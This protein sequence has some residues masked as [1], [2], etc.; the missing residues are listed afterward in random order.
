MERGLTAVER[1]L[2]RGQPVLPLDGVD[3]AEGEGLGPLAVRRDGRAVAAEAQYGHLAI[4]RPELVIGL[5]RA[6]VGEEDAAPAS[7][8]LR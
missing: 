7:R 3:E 4:H 5:A 6:M 8:T 2:Y 1:G